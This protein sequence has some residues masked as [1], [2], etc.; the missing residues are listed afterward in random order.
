[1]LTEITRNYLF[2]SLTLYSSIIPSSQLLFSGFKSSPPPNHEKGLAVCESCG[3]PKIFTKNCGKRTCVYCRTKSIR[4]T[5][6]RK[7]DLMKRLRGCRFMTLTLKSEKELSPDKIK[8]VRSY[9][10]KFIRW[11]LWKKYVFGGLYVI[12]VTYTKSGYH[13]HFHILY[14]GQYF[15]W[16]ELMNGWKR[17]TKGSYIVYIER[18][19]EAKKVSEYMLDYV[20]KVE[21]SNIPKEQYSEVLKGIKLV[22]FFG[23]WTKGKSIKLKAV[24]PFC[25]TSNWMHPFDVERY[26]PFYSLDIQTNS[27]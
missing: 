25:H 5:V 14:E 19:Q 7:G 27:S 18:P 6:A 20:T 22:Q 11:K 12:E 10:Q 4:A 13:Y 15:P 1:M 23:I 24:C 21:K 3:T 2:S 16:A 17:A 8:Q 9:F 26:Y